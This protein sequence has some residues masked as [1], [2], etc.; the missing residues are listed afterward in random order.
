MKSGKRSAIINFLVGHVFAFTQAYFRKFFEV[1][2]LKE[3]YLLLSDGFFFPAIIFLSIGLIS[4]MARD[5]Q[6]DSFRYVLYLGKR[7]FS[8]KNK[9]E[10]D[11]TY[12][13]FKKG[14]QRKEGLLWP[15]LVNGIYFLVMT[16]V[17]N[18]LFGF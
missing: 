1:E 9:N 17:F 10:K 12:G 13:E 5:G 4:W 14:L 6:F 11:M 7:R 15:F 18:A 8:F 3:K 16:I 2:T